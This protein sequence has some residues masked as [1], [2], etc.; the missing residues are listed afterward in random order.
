MAIDGGTVRIKIEGDSKPFEESIHRTTDEVLSAKQILTDFGEVATDAFIEAVDGTD[1]FISS[2]GEVKNAVKAISFGAITAGITAATTGLLK[3]A[4]ASVSETSALEDIQIQMIGLTDSVEAGNKAF[5]MAVNY[6]RNNPFNRFEVTGA[7]NS[8]IQ[9]GAQLDDIPA[10]LEK[11]GKVSLSSGAKID[12]LAYIYQ[13]MISDGRVNTLDLLQLQNQGVNIFGALGKQMGTTAAGVRELVAAGK[14]GVEEVSKAFDSLVSDEAMNRFEVTLSR[15]MDRFKGRMSNMRAA[16]AGYSTSVEGGLEIAENGLYRSVVGFLKKFGEVT[17]AKGEIGKK[18]YEGLEKIGNAIASAINKITAMIEPALNVFQKLLN[19]LGDNSQLL[20]PLL[21]GLALMLTKIAGQIPVFGGIITSITGPV[22]GLARGI[23][24]LAKV[25]PGLTAGLGL[26]IVGFSEAM[27]NDEEFKKSIDELM[28]SIGSI[29]RNVMEAVKDLIPI[30]A[31]LIK[32]LANSQI[33]RGILTTIAGAVKMLSQALAS[34]SP[35]TLAGIISFFGTLKLLNASPIMAVVTAIT[36]LIQYIKSF[37]DEGKSFPETL[38]TIGHNMMTGL[39]NGLVEGAKKVIDFLKSVAQTIINTFKNILGIHSPSTVMYEIGEN[40][41]LGLAEGIEAGGDAAKVAMVNLANDILKASEK[42]IKNKVDFGILDIKEE[43]QEWKKVSKLFTEGSAQYNDAIESMESVR[44]KANL[45]ILDLQKTYNNELDKTI[46][47]IGSMYGLFDEVNLKSGKSSTN[48]LKNLDQQVARMQE[49]AEA[50][51]MIASKGL[52]EKLVKELQSMGV[53]STSELSNIANMTAEE[54]GTLNDLW[55]QK[56]NIANEAGIKQMEGLKNETLDQINDLKNGIDGATV[57]VTDVGGRLVESF[58]E[59]VYGAMPTLESAFAQLGDYIAKA[60]RDLAKQASEKAGLGDGG[61][62]DSLVP[63]V[64]DT[65]TVKEQI[66]AS[67]EKLK[68]ALPNILLGVVGAFG[69]FK[70][71]PK[72]LKS[73]S[74][75]LLKRGGGSEGLSSIVGAIFD[76]MAMGGKFAKTDLANIVEELWVQSKG[77]SNIE[78]VLEMLHGKLTSVSEGTEEIAKTAQKVRRNTQGVESIVSSTEQVSSTMSTAG[79]SMSKAGKIG[80][81]IKEASKT[82][83]MA[84]AAIAAV[85]GALWLAYQAFKDMDFKKLTSGLVE[86]GIA[87]SEMIGLGYLAD[88]AKIDWKG[89]LI[90]AGVAADIALVSL[91]CRVAYEAMKVV[92]FVQFAVALGEMALAV[93][94]FG[95][96]A[97][98]GGMIAGLEALGLIVI[99]GIAGDIALVSIACRKAYDEMKDVDFE[100]FGKAVES[101][102]QA[103][104]SFG[105]M[106]ALMGL[107]IPLEALGWASIIMVCDELVR[108]SKAL[109]EV[110]KNVPD[111]FDPVEQK[112]RNIKKTLEI[113]NGV[114]L[115]TV[116]GAMVTSWSVAP[117]LSVMD[118]YTRVAEQLEKISE[119]NI[120]EEKVNQNLDYVRGALESVRSKTDAISGWLQAWA[121]SAN[122]A[123]V[124]SAGRIIII[125]GEVV[126]A[127]NKLAD[128]K[129]KAGIYTSISDITSVISFIKEST[130]GSSNVFGVAGI[131]GFAAE[132]EAIKQI[133]QNFLDMVP[134]VQRLGQ[135]ENSVAGIESAAKKNIQ[136]FRNIVWDVGETGTGG[137]IEQKGKD[138]DVIKGM[139][140]NFIEMVEPVQKIAAMD[141]GNFGNSEDEGARGVIKRVRQ[142][143]L[144]IGKVDTGGWIEQKEK[145]VGL[146]QSILNRYIE[147][148]PKIVEIAGMTT[149]S[150]AAQSVL[151]NIKN[152]INKIGEIDTSKL[153]DAQAKENLIVSA[154]AILGKLVNF[155]G[156]LNKLTN[157]RDYSIV[158]TLIATVNNMLTN[159]TTSMQSKINGFV[160]VG[161][162]ISSALASG[163][164]ANN[165]LIEQAGVQALSA[166]WGKIKAYDNTLYSQGQQTALKFRQGLYDVDYANA[167]WWAVQGFINGANNRAYGANGVYNAGWKVADVFLQG[168]KARGEQ[169]SPWKTTMESG[170]WAVEGL[171]EGIRNSEDL[172]ITEATTLADQVIDALSMDGVTMSP[173]LDASLSGTAPA[174]EVDEY[175]SMSRGGGVTIQQNNTNYTEYD[176]ERVNNDLAWALSRV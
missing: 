152:V 19:F 40:V 151:E 89:L 86:M 98:L 43:Y 138:V 164:R 4:K 124:E 52:D 167:G 136:A 108:V 142:I 49:W 1:N 114:D 55:L 168:L 27:K 145:D 111:D 44:K 156:E 139:L 175:G 129:V 75:K 150:V 149:N 132:T 57:D 113:I 10:L 104:G 153:G 20:M 5:G 109:V 48:I 77:G 78:K 24:D 29:V 122:A 101:M 62:M 148:I 31:D 35:E 158:N 84:A 8:L 93:V 17:D 63:G 162:N 74:E 85:A 80:S 37:M 135:S 45:K 58:S 47:K 60:Q 120:N 33:V 155:Q 95:G 59:G 140:N 88:K 46:S 81:T 2:L 102:I 66:T 143:V 15:Q 133:V 23:K 22:Y 26:L 115:G 67:V 130:T 119:L 36:L 50:Q 30:I 127:L 87:V 6:F 18:L 69:A 117:L 70:F 42:I 106:S 110:D 9:F 103:L 146:I 100:K 65:G 25:F 68:K 99:A 169:G 38:L 121:D 13:R 154:T 131:A 176:I 34:I 3:M 166:Y 92:D 16:I 125:Y 128:F 21:A 171:V 174:M 56:Q 159:I 83:I 126:D 172:L 112:V 39:F 79:Q 165:V 134:T 118:M 94:A 170:A 137:W 163:L 97:A 144:D 51:N 82:I 141:T 61:I 160:N 11:L 96:L 54:L 32:T 123:S 76:K 147:L 41:S 161:Q 72:I 64:P 28:A 71:G 53:G 173:S 157:D 7:T 12:Q 107:F 116:I 105:G 14:V 90:I 91:A 73:I